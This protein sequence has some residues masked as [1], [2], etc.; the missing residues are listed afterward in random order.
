MLFFLPAK[1]IPGIWINF[2]QHGS[3]K[4]SPCNDLLALVKKS[5]ILDRLEPLTRK[6]YKTFYLCPSCDKIYWSGSHKEGMHR[7]LATLENTVKM[8]G[9]AKHSRSIEHDTAKQ[10]G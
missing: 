4:T 1:P 8:Q 7:I 6:Y 2:Y 3:N 5:T 9:L 10:R